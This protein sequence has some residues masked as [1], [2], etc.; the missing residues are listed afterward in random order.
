MM[1]LSWEVFVSAMFNNIR[2]NFTVKEMQQQ[3]LL[4]R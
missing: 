2:K 1:Y 4:M 3:I